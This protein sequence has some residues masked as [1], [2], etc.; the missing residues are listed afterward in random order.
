VRILQEIKFDG[1]DR[2]APGY[3]VVKFW[4]VGPEKEFLGATV[5]GKTEEG[6]TIEN[7]QIP[8]V[9]PLFSAVMTP[10]RLFPR[11]VP[12][13]CLDGVVSGRVTVRS[14]VVVTI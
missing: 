10:G 5:S 11:S 1:R 9:P 13:G 8:A 12:G 3:Y 14:L 7:Q 4:F 6:D 2:L